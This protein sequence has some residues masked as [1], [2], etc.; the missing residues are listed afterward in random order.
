MEWGV[1]FSFS[2]KGGWEG[3][4]F[5]IFSEGWLRDFEGGSLRIGF[6]LVLPLSLVSGF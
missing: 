4:L 6:N 5:M 1:I 2:Y 3:I